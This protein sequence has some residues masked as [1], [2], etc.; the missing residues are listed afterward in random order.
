MKLNT[1]RRQFFHERIDLLGDKRR[2]ARARMRG[3][4]SHIFCSFDQDAGPYTSSGCTGTSTAVED[5]GGGLP[6]P[7]SSD[8]IDLTGTRREIG[9]QAPLSNP[10]SPQWLDADMSGIRKSITFAAIPFHRDDGK[11]GAKPG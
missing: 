11:S 9:P 8:A 5:L 1:P 10:D 4:G 7:R 3:H 6:R 2:D